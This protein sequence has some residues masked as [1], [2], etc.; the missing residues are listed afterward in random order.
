MT[1]SADEADEPVRRILSR[2][3]FDSDYKVQR[4]ARFG[5]ETLQG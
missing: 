1:V 2:L 4:W 3:V 5:L